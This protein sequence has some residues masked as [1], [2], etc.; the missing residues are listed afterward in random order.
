MSTLKFDRN[1]FFSTPP[2]WTS[3]TASRVYHADAKAGKRVSSSMLKEF[4][5]SPAHYA[6]IV[7]GNG[8]RTHSPAFR[9]GNALHKLVLEGEGAYRNSFVVGGPF[10]ER[11]G[12]VFAHGT[13]AF[14][15]WLDEY[16][17]DSERV[18][19]PAE[20]ADL[21]RMAAGLARHAEAARL[22][23]EGW[24]ERTVLAEVEGVS[25]Q[26]RPDWLRADGV[27]VEVKTAADL[28]RFEE[29]ARRFDY[30]HQLAF[31]RDVIRAAGGGE[32]A[33]AAVVLEKRA[34]FRVGVWRFDASV[35]EPYSAQNRSA[36]KALVRCR[37]EGRWPTGYEGTRAFP[38]A[39]LPP[40]WL[41]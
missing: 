14:K 33:M 20:E 9:L 16:G 26:A 34:P 38:P 1:N 19:T 11:T 23:A 31:Y 21:R 37:R 32:V 27:C 3:D 8:Q 22:L 15:M 35:L 2:K 24:P 4:R 25:C 39:G 29:N 36:L 40:L 6:A 17:L 7:N 41:N 28:G 5:H 10:N 18:V 13:Q 12:R 30:L